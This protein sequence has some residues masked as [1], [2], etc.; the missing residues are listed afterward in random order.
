MDERPQN[1]VDV[2]EDMSLDVKRGLLE[3]KQST[4]RDPPL[5]TAS[6]LLAEQQRLLFS[7]P[8]EVDLEEEL[9][10][11]LHCTFVFICRGNI[12]SS[13]VTLE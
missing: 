11:H 1:V 4:L 10:L 2:F 8:E 6:E 13:R 7:Q 9:V 5:S 12:F 3:D